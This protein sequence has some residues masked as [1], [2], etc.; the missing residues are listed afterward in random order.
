MRYAT[1]I[2]MLLIAAFVV[3]SPLNAAD[4]RNYRFVG[5]D[6][7]QIVEAN[8]LYIYTQDVLRFKGALDKK[9][10]FSVGPEGE[11]FPL[12]IENLKKAFPA[13]HGFHDLLDMTFKGDADLTRYDKFHSMFKVNRV[14][15]ASTER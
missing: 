4:Q 14:L 3:A 5:N 8:A 10:F 2:A 6:K 15:A 7:Y 1:Y 9:W 13:N 12:T 11:V